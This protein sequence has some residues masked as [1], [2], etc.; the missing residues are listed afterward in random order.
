MKIP[1][2]AGI[3]LGDFLKSAVL[4]GYRERPDGEQVPLFGAKVKSPGPCPREECAGE[5][6]LR[7]NGSYARQVI[8]GL[9][10]F[11]VLI[12]RFRCELCGKTISRPYSFL[13]PYRRFTGKLICRGIE[14]YGGERKE[15]SY[16]EV[17][18]DLS[19]FVD[20]ADASSQTALEQDQI[21]WIAAGTGKDGFCPARNTVFTWVDFVCKST[22]KS[23]Q[24]FEKEVVLR[25]FDV[26]ALPSESQFEN[27]NAYKAGLQPRYIHQQYKRKQL[28]KL[29]YGL[30]LGRLLVGCA[31][32]AME[33][34][35]AYFLQSAETCAD[36]L[37]DVLQRL[38]MTHTF[39]QSNF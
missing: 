1:V 27:K 13:A 2:F 3:S 38:P 18:A 19:I 10:M 14:L 5:G 31:Q 4:V 25:N 9:R 33:D 7:R 20:E 29:T 35:R 8:E 15:T 11:L 17:C 34:L 23:V 36:L 24:Q 37:S 6:K 32:D 21:T 16:R 22:G 26:K 39:E 30:A 28:D 12:Y